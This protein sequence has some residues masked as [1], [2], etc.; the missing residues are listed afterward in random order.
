MSALPG[1]IDAFVTE[2]A[3][4][5]GCDPAL[6]A[7]PCL[8]VVTAAI[9]N[10]HAVR[11]KSGWTEPSVLWTGAIGESGT[12]K[13]PAFE[14]ALE[15]LQS[16]QIEAFKRHEKALSRFA[17]AQKRYSVLYAS[18]KSKRG[19]EDP[20]GEPRCPEAERLIVQDTTVE[21]LAVRLAHAPRGL[22]LAREEL[23]GWLRS[24]DA[25]R[26]GRG[27]DE[28]Q[29]LA[30]YGAR[31]LTVD[32][33]SGPHVTIVVPRAAVSITGTVQPSV[34]RDVL[35]RKHFESGLVARFLLALPPRATKRW[36][37]AVVAP[38]TL[39]AYDRAIAELLALRPVSDEDGVQAPVEVALDAEAHE[40]WVEFYNRHAQR[41][42]A[43]TGHEAAMLA[44]IEGVAARLA[45]L[46]YCVRVAGDPTLGL[47]I[48][49]TSLRAAVRIAEWFAHE[50][51]RVY[52]IFR[53]SPGAQARR[54]LGE[55]IRR[56]GGRVTARDVTRGP[57]RFRGSANLA[58]AALDD[59]VRDGLGQWEDV[60]PDRR[61]GRPTRAF[62][63]RD[64]TQP[65]SAD[66]VATVTKPPRQA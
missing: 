43:A 10:A 48:D 65:E 58:E 61:A 39:A 29:W 59:L 6:V 53:E 27:G 33:K 25:Y 40:I 2:T 4:A 56:K 31:C 22:L 19:T 45:L 47:R 66:S 50:A 8:A 62:V 20:P 1:P 46:S 34:M 57:R 26:G 32:R 60:S 5:L 23:S 44:K 3:G 30:M 52:A 37:S 36:T 51:L 63:L 64:D 11:L 14:A 38:A 12:L 54:R 15:P 18:W 55:W 28:A 21:A 9:G 41:Q 7:L 49:A 17:I 42:A 13:S 35:G 16:R 24:F